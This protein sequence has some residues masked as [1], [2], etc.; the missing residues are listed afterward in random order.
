VNE[1]AGLTPDAL[2]RS[3][4]SFTRARVLIV[5]DIMLDVYLRGDAERISPEAPVPVV[6]VEEEKFLLGGGGNVARNIVALGGRAALVG[7]RGA[8]AA[9]ET[10][11]L[12]LEAEGVDADLAVE[13]SRPTTV[14]TRILARGQQMLRFD[15]EKPDPRDPREEGDLLRRLEAALPDCGAIVI[16]D[17]GKGVVSPSLMSRLRA[18][19]RALPGPVP[20]LVDP[21]PHNLSAYSEV[22]LLTPNAKE[23][24][25]LT[26]MPVHTPAALAAAGRA[27]MERL[28]CPHLVTTLGAQGMAV[29]ESRQAIFHLPTMA[30]Q[31]F[32][33]TGAG[34][35]VIATLALSLAG[36]VP[37]LPA[38]VLA[39][40]AAG[41]VVAE[42]GAATTTA[43]ALADSIISVPVPECWG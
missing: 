42:I 13:S 36:G 41:M 29:F 15:R 11:R 22:T 17:Y 14:K 39:N 37:L 34:D 19:V 4:A 12:L 28:G 18:L 5:G 10:L 16:S 25:E 33:V 2:R 43:A 6:Q 21:R 31:V 26:R 1:G 32:D 27:L 9:G 7:A 8:D 23:T 35:T 30:R 24:S 40:F 20:I 3:I 38:C